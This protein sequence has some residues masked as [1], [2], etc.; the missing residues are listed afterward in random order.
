MFKKL[1]AGALATG[2]ALTGGMGVSA[3]TPT[4]DSVKTLSSSNLPYSSVC[5]PSSHTLKMSMQNTHGSF[6]NY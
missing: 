5:P 6:A 2:F 4:V 3:S 1:I